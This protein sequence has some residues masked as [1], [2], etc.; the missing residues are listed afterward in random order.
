MAFQNQCIDEMVHDAKFCRCFHQFINIMII[1][2]FYLLHSILFYQ[3][4]MTA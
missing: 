2:I 1:E 4:R 3:K